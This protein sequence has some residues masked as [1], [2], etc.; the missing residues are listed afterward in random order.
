M[1]KSTIENE[2]KID[3]KFDK[4]VSKK[5]GKTTK[6]EHGFETNNQK[7]IA[8]LKIKL[9]E[10]EDKLLRE[11]AENENLRKGMKRSLKKI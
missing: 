9:K 7:I 11:L 8:D 2:K 5:D 3:K 1:K 10:A 6:N 4:N